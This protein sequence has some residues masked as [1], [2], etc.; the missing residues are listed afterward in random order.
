MIR[1]GR[2]ARQTKTT[3]TTTFQVPKQEKKTDVHDV[4]AGTGW[5]H[6][7][8]Y[9]NHPKILR[10]KRVSPRANKP[11]QA[12]GAGQSVRTCFHRNCTLAAEQF[13]I[14]CLHS[15]NNLN[16]MIWAAGSQHCGWV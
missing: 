6:Q 7:E 2:S 4:I 3:T 16:L 10:K 12:Q 15:Q 11:L 1:A 8:E 9:Q 14:I 5:K 13:N